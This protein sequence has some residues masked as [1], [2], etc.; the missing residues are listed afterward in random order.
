MKKGL[1]A[2]AFA[3]EVAVRDAMKY[4]KQAGYDSIELN[5]DEKGEIG[6]HTQAASLKKIATAAKR[7][8]IEISSVSTGL[9]WAYNMA[10]DDAD[11]RKMAAKVLNKQIDTAA[12][13]GCNAILVIPGT[14]RAPFGDKP[15]V[16]PDKVWD[17]ALEGIK[18][19]TAKA[20]DVGVSIAIENV[21]NTFLLSATEM[22]DFID[23]CDSKAV[24][25]YFDPANAIAFGIP[26]QWV[27]VLGK[28]IKRIHFKD[29]RRAVGNLDGFVHLL[30]GD[31][32]YPS[33]MAE[34]KAI[35]YNGYV[36]A[37]IFPYA[38]GLWESQIW[39][40]SKAMDFI[41]G[42]AKPMKL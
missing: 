39:T 24:G 29:F 36:T 33:L 20:E 8:K 26:Q 32:D 40:S 19:A 4:A 15:P 28:R 27:R 10:S 14:V 18:S 34:L 7:M 25:S 16:D 3:P 31:M 22:R 13:L 38:N 1:N 42:R 41:L 9:Y 37:E 17:R 30:E 6:M 5:L 11:E 23:A 21:W 35:R 12:G 2:W